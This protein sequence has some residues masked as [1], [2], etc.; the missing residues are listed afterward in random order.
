MPKFFSRSGPSFSKAFF[1][2]GWLGTEQWVPSVA[3][4]PSLV[5][6]SMKSFSRDTHALI[7][8]MVKPAKRSVATIGFSILSTTLLWSNGA[9][10]KILATQDFYFVDSIGV[11]A[12]GSSQQLID[13]VI[14]NA[15]A[16][17]LAT[18]FFP[19]GGAFT[20]T[21]A[22]GSGHAA[23]A[24]NFILGNTTVIPGI[25]SFSGKQVLSILVSSDIEQINKTLGTSGVLDL[26]F[27][28]IYPSSVAVGDGGV[29]NYSMIQLLKPTDTSIENGLSDLE[30]AV[31]RASQGLV[32][33]PSIDN[34]NL[35]YAEEMPYIVSEG[36]RGWRYF[37]KFLQVCGAGLTGVVTG[38]CAGA[39]VGAGVG[40]V[41]GGVPTGGVGAL[42][43]AATGAIAGGVV[44]GV[45]GGAGGTFSKAG[46]VIVENNK[47]NDDGPK[48]PT[49][50][51]LTPPSG[52][53]S[54]GELK[55]VPGPLPILGA[56]AAFGWS[57]KLRKRLKSSKPE[58]I[59][60]TAV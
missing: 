46:D 50:T 37:G 30:I 29:M 33:Y 11:S 57:R 16:S 34:T 15:Q 36:S 32:V 7:I 59:S 54:P 40:A 23:D 43:G 18:T 12:S 28:S 52:L 5:M 2:A 53:P 60:T 3:A 24:N 21:M 47:E 27:S 41:A 10:A 48:P 9:Y 49:T 31:S 13:L 8:K 17:S 22:F 6:K 25:F 51:Q 55:Q 39:T 14:A 1:T 45:L 38:G 58:V 56:A 26:D 4:T 42:P 20:Q 44:G 19:G 35:L